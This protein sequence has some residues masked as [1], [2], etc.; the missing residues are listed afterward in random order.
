MSNSPKNPFLSW[1]L[2]VLL[3]LVWGTSF[4]L[5]KKSLATYSVTEVAAGRLFLAS[6]FFL[7]I[8]L[9]T[10]APFDRF[11]YLL[12]SALMGYVIP[13]FLFSKAGTRLNSSLSGMLNSLSPLFTLIIGFVFYGQPRRWLQTV[14]ILIG[15]M[16]SLLLIFAQKTGSINLTDPYALLIVSATVMYGININT[17]VKHLSHLP[18]LT[19]T[20]WTFAFIGPISLVALLTSDFFPKLA[21]PQNLQPSL[22]LLILGLLGSGLAAILFN[23][24]VQLASGI[25]AS[26]VTYLIPIVAIGWGLWDGENITPQQFVGMGVILTGI[27]LVNKK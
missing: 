27:Y 7:P 17:I 1:L 12:V 26:S 23:R 22:Y 10:H 24:I 18:A 25:F 11:P 5:M 8:M 14:G 3:A 9:R 16:G 13:A 21:S 2:L 15:L 19:M 4:I 6:L 20:A